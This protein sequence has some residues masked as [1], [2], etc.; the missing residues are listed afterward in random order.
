MECESWL[1]CNKYN[2]WYGVDPEFMGAGLHPKICG[3]ALL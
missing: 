1:E 2:N 3:N